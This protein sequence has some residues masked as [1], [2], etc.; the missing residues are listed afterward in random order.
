MKKILITLA[1]AACAAAVQASAFNWTASGTNASKTFYGASGSTIPGLTVYLMDVAT[2]SQGALVEAIRAGGAIT[3]YT[4][5]KSQTLDSNSR[6]TAT[7][8]SY[9]ETG[10]TYNFYMAIVDGDNIFVSNS[11]EVYG[12]LADTSDVKY[13]GIKTATQTV[14][15]DAAYSSAGWYTAAVPEPTSGLLMLLGIAGLALKRKRA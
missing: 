11:V 3:D 7:E 2:V 6:I 8:F 5:V 13:S 4:A 10:T 15:G 12:Q 1:V 14:L 9:G